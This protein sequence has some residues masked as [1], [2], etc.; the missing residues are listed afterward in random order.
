MNSVS[1][2]RTLDSV[3]AASF[4]AWMSSHSFGHELKSHPSSQLAGLS[5]RTRIDA[6]D[7]HPSRVVAAGASELERDIRVDAERDSALLTTVAISKAPP[8]TAVRIDEQKQALAVR[9][10]YGLRKRFCR[11]ICTSAR[12]ISCYPQ[13]EPHCATYPNRYPQVW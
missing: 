3:T 13:R 8:A 2:Q 12:D 6:L 10:L 9:E 11:A 1:I 5:V 7:E 4:F